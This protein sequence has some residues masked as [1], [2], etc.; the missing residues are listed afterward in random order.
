MSELGFYIGNKFSQKTLNFEISNHV[1]SQVPGLN[2]VR[3]SHL[4]TIPPYSANII[5]SIVDNNTSN[6]FLFQPITVNKIHMAESPNNSYTPEEEENFLDGPSV[7]S[8]VD[9]D[10]I[11]STVNFH[12]PQKQQQTELK[13]EKREKEK[14]PEEGKLDRKHKL[15]GQIPEGS[16]SKPWDNTESHG[17]PPPLLA[18]NFPRPIRPKISQ[19]AGFQFRPSFPP[20]NIPSTSQASGPQLGPRFP[21]PKGPR[22]NFHFNKRSRF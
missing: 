13:P 16:R 4:Q 5:E 7:V 2:T 22:P 18:G 17:H 11:R 9:S 6:N 10:L 1:P 14:K 21:P 20:P 3:V 19:S 15:D 12:G 8:H